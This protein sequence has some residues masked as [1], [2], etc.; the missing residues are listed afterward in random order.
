[1]MRTFC[2]ATFY[3]SLLIVQNTSLLEHETWNTKYLWLAVLLPLPSPPLLIV[4]FLCFCIRIHYFWH[5]FTTSQRG[6]EQKRKEIMTCIYTNWVI[7]ICNMISG[8]N[9]HRWPGVRCSCWPPVG[10]GQWWPVSLVAWSVSCGTS[11]HTWHVTASW[12]PCP[13]SWST[14]SSSSS[15]SSSTTPSPGCGTLPGGDRGSHCGCW[16]KISEIIA[17]LSCLQAN[18]VSTPAH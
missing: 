1:M 3:A 12:W 5:A 6:R 8:W 2:G 15:P 9:F 10:G 11:A 13:G 18:I 17:I 4:V 16:T 7:V 14:S